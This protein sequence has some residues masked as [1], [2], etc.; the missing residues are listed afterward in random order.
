MKHLIDMLIINKDLQ[1]E[2][3]TTNAVTLTKRFRKSKNEQGIEDNDVQI[4]EPNQKEMKPVLKL[5]RK[6]AP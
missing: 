3:I 5:K 2:G 6:R 1:A 4:I